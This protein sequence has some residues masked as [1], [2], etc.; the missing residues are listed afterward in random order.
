LFDNTKRLRQLI[1]ELEELSAQV[2]AEAE[3]WESR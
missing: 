3:G 2:V 1:N